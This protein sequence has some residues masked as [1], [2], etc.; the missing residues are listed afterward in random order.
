LKSSS[1][2]IYTRSV[3]IQVFMDKLHVLVLKPC[4]SCS[5][6]QST[7]FSESKVQVP[8]VSTQIFYCSYR[9]R[10]EDHSSHN[11]IIMLT[12]KRTLNAQYN[13]AVKRD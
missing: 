13:Y 9:L 12:E 4:N 6:G 2:H 7:Y 5:R 11:C 1:I 8:S 10:T 3:K